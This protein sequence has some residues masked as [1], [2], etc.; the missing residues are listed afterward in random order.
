MSN[1]YEEP[2]KLPLHVRGWIIIGLVAASWTGIV[3]AIRSY[4][5]G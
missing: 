1:D 5:H 3:L 2:G 4:L